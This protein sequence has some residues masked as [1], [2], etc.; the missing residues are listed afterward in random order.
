VRKATGLEKD[1]RAAEGFV[2]WRRGHFFQRGMVALMTEQTAVVQTN[3]ISRIF[4]KGGALCGNTQ[5][6]PVKCLGF[7]LGVLNFYARTSAFYFLC[8]S[9]LGPGHPVIIHEYLS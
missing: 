6:D 8:S 2:F 9:E 1:G 5:W 4:M 7:S 3:G